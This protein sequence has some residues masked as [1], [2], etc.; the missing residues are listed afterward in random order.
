MPAPFSG[1]QIER[2][3]KTLGLS[4]RQFA[5]KLGVTQGSVSHWEE[6]RRVPSGPVCVILEQITLELA[7]RKKTRKNSA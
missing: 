7:S 2:L 6:S 3:R 4:Q 1:S 5:E